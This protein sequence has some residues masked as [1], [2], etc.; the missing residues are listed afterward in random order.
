M[1][2][3]I[4][5]LSKILPL[6]LYPLGMVSILMLIA[7][8]NFWQRPYRAGISLLT[9]FLILVV[10]SSGWFADRMVAGLE[11]QYPP[12][13]FPPRAEAIIVLGGSTYPPNYPRQ[14][15]EVNEAGD[16]VLYGAKLYREKRAPKVILSG[17]RIEWK[18]GGQAEAIDMRTLMETMGVPF[19]DILLEPDSLNTYEN[20]RN[21]KKLLE[22][23]KLEGRFLLVTS[24]MH[25]P[26]AKAIFDK[27]DINVIPAPTDFLIEPNRENVSGR[28]QL[29][30][31][32]P[33][34]EAL[35]QTT[36][37]MKERIGYQI[38]RM[39]GWV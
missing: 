28:E 33:D 17:G 22:E 31:I 10:T 6:A 29:L 11:T 35:Q 14:W 1:S 24:A 3:F 4:L 18:D 32:L 19:K 36:K 8:I 25:M 34:A 7:I 5:F 2:E 30:N 13:A 12:L 39:R 37:A 15:P 23:E 20:A 27:Q 16:R 26:R 21:V 9:A 38:Y